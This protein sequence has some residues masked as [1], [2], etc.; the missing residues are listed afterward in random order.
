[1]YEGWTLSLHM[2]NLCKLVCACMR[3]CLCIGIQVSC[4]L[5]CGYEFKYASTGSSLLT[6]C[7]YASSSCD[8]LIYTY[9]MCMC[10]RCINI[11]HNNNYAQMNINFIIEQI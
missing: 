10:A 4:G 2:L 5:V 1:M 7:A 3:V 11:I 9:A 8:I 6:V